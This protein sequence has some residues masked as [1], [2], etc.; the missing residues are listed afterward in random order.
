MIAYIR[1]LSVLK[2]FKSL[3]SNL[4]LADISVDVP[5]NLDLSSIRG[6]GL[7][8]GEEEL[9]QEAEAPQGQGHSEFVLFSD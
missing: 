2:A 6:R 8:P 4:L 5:D 3:N 1:E 7:Q 9:P